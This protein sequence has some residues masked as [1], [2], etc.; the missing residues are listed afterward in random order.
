[1]FVHEHRELLCRQQQLDSVCADPASLAETPTSYMLVD[2]FLVAPVLAF[3]VPRLHVALPE[4]RWV[5]MWSGSTFE[6][7]S[8]GAVDV[9]TPIGEPA[10]FYR[11]GCAE[12]ERLMA[13]LREQGLLRSRP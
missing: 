4:G 12:G 9:P 8:R 5:H 7:T 10:V 2:Q 13:A 11:A 6:V 1:M 3:G